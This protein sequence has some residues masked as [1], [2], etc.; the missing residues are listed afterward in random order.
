M[1]AVVIYLVI[2][3]LSALAAY[4]IR[5]NSRII[6]NFLLLV[7]VAFVLILLISIIVEQIS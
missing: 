5:A 6:S 3:A 1:R 4:I 2:A 7:S